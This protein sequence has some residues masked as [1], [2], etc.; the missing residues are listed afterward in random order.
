MPA[1]RTTL[2]FFLLVIAISNKV[3]SQERAFTG[4]GRYQQEMSSLQRAIDGNFYGSAAGY[5]KER[6][7]NDQPRHPYTY[8]WSLCALFAGAPPGF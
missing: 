3:L 6:P 4:T 8:L 2:S 5:Y 1:N 7:G